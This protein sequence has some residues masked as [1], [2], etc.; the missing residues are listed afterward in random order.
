M[1]RGCSTKNE[2]KQRG[3]EGV[4][5]LFAYSGGRSKQQGERLRNL[6]EA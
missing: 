3:M 6:V 2:T 4:L 1:S 5:G